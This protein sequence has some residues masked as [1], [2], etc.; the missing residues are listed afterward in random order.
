M[1]QETDE[2]LR[3]RYPH[4]KKARVFLE[5][6]NRILGM[7]KSFNGGHTETYIRWSGCEAQ[8]FDVHSR[9]LNRDDPS[10]NK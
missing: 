3:I 10:R 6:L 1:H 9:D 4:I 2:F 7:F 8:W 5:N